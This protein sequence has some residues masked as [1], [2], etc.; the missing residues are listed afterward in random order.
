MK[1]NHTAFGCIHVLV[2][3]T[4]I[5]KSCMTDEIVVKA[6]AENMYLVSFKGHMICLHTCIHDITM[7]KQTRD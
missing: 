3:V 1:T 7:V 6:A 5:E 4:V 2:S